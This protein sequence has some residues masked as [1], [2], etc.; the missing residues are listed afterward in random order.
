VSRKK[1]FCFFNIQYYSIEWT[2]WDRFEVL[3][4]MTLRQF[5][6]YFKREHKL[7]I[8]M[9]SQGYSTIFSFY[10]PAG[11]RNERMDLPVS[12]VVRRVSNK[13][14]EPHVTALVFELDCSQVARDDEEGEYDVDEEGE[15]VEVPYV[16]Y[17]LPSPATE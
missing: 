5:L 16:R 14:I 9:L 3:G 7:E 15:Y 12:E 1:L 11:K 17:V 6:D 8:K 13:E 4:E 2:L 10:M